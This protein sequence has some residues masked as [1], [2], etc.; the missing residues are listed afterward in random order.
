MC[1]NAWNESVL[2]SNATL[3]SCGE[4]PRDLRPGSSGGGVYRGEEGGGVIRGEQKISLQSHVVY[5][6]CHRFM[7]VQFR[8]VV[9]VCVCVCACVCVCMCVQH[10]QM[11]KTSMTEE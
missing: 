6:C 8:M 10:R 11:D 1:V 5:H 9:C 2:G 3:P 7:S 4:N